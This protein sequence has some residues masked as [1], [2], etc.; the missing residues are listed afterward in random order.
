MTWTY[1]HLNPC[2]FVAVQ[3]TIKPSMYKP[4]KND[5]LMGDIALVI[6]SVPITHLAPIELPASAMNYLPPDWLTVVGWG[7]TEEGELSENLK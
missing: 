3:S 1:H 7:T 5:N 6:L 2:R 4:N